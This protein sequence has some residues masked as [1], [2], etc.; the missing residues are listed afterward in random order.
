MGNQVGIGFVFF[1]LGI[2]I[3]ALAGD[4]NGLAF[5]LGVG[6]LFIGIMIW[7]FSGVWSFAGVIDN[8][9]RDWLNDDRS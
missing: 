4:A 1:I 8:K 5:F 9:T 2:I 7:L 6:L 3:M